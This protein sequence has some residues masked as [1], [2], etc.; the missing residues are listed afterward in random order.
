LLLA[1][2]PKQSKMLA[3]IT[4]FNIEVLPITDESDELAD[5]YIAEGVI[6]QYTNLHRKGGF[7]R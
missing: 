5:I 6:R 7:A 4:E 3:L 2:E 1:P